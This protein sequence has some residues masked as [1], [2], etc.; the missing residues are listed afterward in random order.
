[1]FQGKYG[2]YP[3]DRETYH[4]LKK[5]NMA[6][7]KA[8]HAKARWER[9]DRK[10]PQNRVIRN[11]IR[12]S[13]GRVV[14]YQAPVPMPEPAVSPIFCNKILKNVKIDKKGNYHKDG[15]IETF[16][17]MIGLSIY[18][19]YRKARYP[20]ATEAECTSLSMSL[21]EIDELYSKLQ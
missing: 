17:E 10:E 12:N 11:K 4:K 18:E 2:W 14:G 16:I 3:C 19:D 1:M 20:V 6:W 8:L 9:W 13:N 5:L 15:K 21:S 7:N